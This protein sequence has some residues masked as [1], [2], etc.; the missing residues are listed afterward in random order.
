MLEKV[1][2]VFILG[3][4]VIIGSNTPHVHIC[5]SDYLNP[6]NKLSSSAICIQFMDDIFGK[7]LH[8]I[9]ELFRINEFLNESRRGIQFIDKQANY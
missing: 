2:I 7:S 6:E 9:P 1:L 5:N 8:D 3:D 4:I